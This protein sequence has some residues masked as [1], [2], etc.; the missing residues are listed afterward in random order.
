MI[1][2]K[3]ISADMEFAARPVLKDRDYGFQDGSRTPERLKTF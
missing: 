2:M 1:A 3:W